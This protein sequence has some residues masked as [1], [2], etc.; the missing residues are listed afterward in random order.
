MATITKL[1]SA[2]AKSGRGFSPSCFGFHLDCQS[3]RCD[4]Y[5]RARSIIMSIFNLQ[6]PSQP[7]STYLTYIDYLSIYVSTVVQPF[8]VSIYP[9]HRS[10]SENFVNLTKD[11]GSMW[12]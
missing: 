10:V 9:R 11:V 8:F 6:M 5:I 3:C 12:F 1:L 2:V 7:L 4:S